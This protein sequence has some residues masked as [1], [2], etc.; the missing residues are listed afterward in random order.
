MSN[1]G[2]PLT[3]SVPWGSV[4][5]VYAGTVTVSDSVDVMVIVDVESVVPV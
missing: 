2:I 5:V 1:G 4:V 3:V